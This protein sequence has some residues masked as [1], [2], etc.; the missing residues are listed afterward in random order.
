M[1]AITFFMNSNNS[2]KPVEFIT[3]MIMFV[4]TKK[5]DFY[6]QTHGTAMGT[7]L[8]PKYANLFMG[9]F[10]AE[11]VYHNNLLF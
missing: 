3:E 1:E 5:Y 10:E 2:D 7:P 4:L 6:L 11:F 8:A 9:K